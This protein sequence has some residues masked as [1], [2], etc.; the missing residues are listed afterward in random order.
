MSRIKIK[1]AKTAGFCMGVRRA[2]E[3]A[4]SM[5]QSKGA[6]DVY[7]YGPLI[8]NPQAV[9]FLSEKGI[10]PVDDLEKIGGGSI[11]IR[12]HGISPEERG[13]IEKTGMRIIDAT[14]PK[15]KHVQSIIRRH[16]LEDYEILIIGDRE[17]PEVEG[18]LG[19][20][21]GRGIVIGAHDDL[22]SIPCFKKLCIVA[23]TTQSKDEYVKIAKEVAEKNPGCLVFK[24]IC[25]STERRQAEIKELAAEMDAIFI[26][27]GRN[28][29]NTKRLAK[30]A[31]SCGKPTF[32]IETASEIRD[33]PL[34]QFNSIGISA[35]ASTPKWIIK[36][37][38]DEL[39][40]TCEASSPLT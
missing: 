25:D 5:A 37:I 6:E 9:D 30:V 1:L 31:E 34:H 13:K 15:V 32:H 17:H 29:A 36:E 22:K 11:I 16:S 39:N 2:I 24:T 12:A 10:K 35:G 38:I 40:R 27:G 28:S 23:Q 14:C 26:V 18:L 8:H 4:L 21:N 7:T 19:C 33:I 20:A 3:I